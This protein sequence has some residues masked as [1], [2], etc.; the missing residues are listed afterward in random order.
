M[1]SLS[2]GESQLILVRFGHFTDM[3]FDFEIWGWFARLLTRQIISVW[4]RYRHTSVYKTCPIVQPVASCSRV[5][6]ACETEL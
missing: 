5:Q 4:W 3:R 2:I 6:L 1:E